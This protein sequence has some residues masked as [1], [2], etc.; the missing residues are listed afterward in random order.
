MLKKYVFLLLALL[1]A[2][3]FSGCYDDTPKPS[4]DVTPLEGAKEVTFHGDLDSV[5]QNG[6]ID[7]NGVATGHLSEWGLLNTRW[8]VSV[9]SK[10]C[11]YVKIVTDEPINN[12]PGITSGNTY[13]FY[14]MENNCL[15]YAQQQVWDDG[16]LGRA[17][18]LM[19]L[20]AD[21]SRKN[22]YADEQG[23]TIYNTDGEVIGEAQYNLSLFSTYMVTVTCQDP[24]VAIQDKL[25]I[26]FARV[27]Y[28][29]QLHS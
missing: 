26:N 6:N 25:A 28:L 12:Q 11:F 19:F 20:D 21:G 16:C 27:K 22:Y 10:D 17:W 14:D 5:E 24:S 18:Y 13:G 4:A 23:E 2:L 7:I 15:G 8:Y 9:D 1:L 3:S 29:K